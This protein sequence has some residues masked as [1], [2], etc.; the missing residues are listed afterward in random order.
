[1]HSSAASTKR[2]VISIWIAWPSARNADLPARWPA[3]RSPKTTNA[4]SWGWLSKR[5]ANF[6]AQRS[7]FSHIGPRQADMCA[8]PGKR[9]PKIGEVRFVSKADMTALLC[10]ARFTPESRHRNGNKCRPRIATDNRYLSEP[11]GQLLHGERGA[12]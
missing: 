7:R 8:L 11:T 6:G 10:V 2:P 1:M 3:I 5:R 9:G 4:E 12:H